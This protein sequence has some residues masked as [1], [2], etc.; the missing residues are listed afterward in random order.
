MNGFAIAYDWLYDAWSDEE[1]TAIMWSLIT[2]GINKGLEAH[3]QEAWFLSAE[4][5]ADGNWNC[6]VLP[7][8]AQVLLGPFRY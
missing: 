7:F 1:K 3:E 2:L 5:K 4:G 8:P 6:I